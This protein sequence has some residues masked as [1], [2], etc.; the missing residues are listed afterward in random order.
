MIYNALKMV[1]VF[2]DTK[3][4]EY[5]EF[6]KMWKM[7]IADAVEH[8]NLKK[9]A[10]LN[11]VR[12]EVAEFAIQIA[13]MVR[14]SCEHEFKTRLSSETEASIIESPD[15]I[16]T[17]QPST[18]KAYDN[19]VKVVHAEPPKTNINGR[20]VV[21]LSKSNSAHSNV[22]DVTEEDFLDVIIFK[23]VCFNVYI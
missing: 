12:E 20:N 8:G 5:L 6:R 4:I 16:N 17:V 23:K 9:S 18:S 22:P 19:H 14:A 21:E 13:E 2:Y 15:H 10:D 7:K 1:R 11:E 3:T